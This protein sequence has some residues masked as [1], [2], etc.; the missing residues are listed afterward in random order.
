MMRKF[1]LFLL[2]IGLSMCQLSAN[3][4]TR[5]KIDAERQVF[6]TR[7]ASEGTKMVRVVACGSTAEKAIEQ[8][9]CDA[10]AAISFTGAKGEGEMDA[11]PPVLKDGREQYTKHKK[12]F[13]KFFNKGTYLNY[14]SRVNSTYPAGKDNIKTSKGR[15]VQ[16]YLIVDWATLAKY[17]KDAGFQTTISGLTDF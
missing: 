11:I 12:E 17:F 7:S 14:V 4:K 15:K 9:M 10:V 6:A 13:N 5:F 1:L 16:V 2:T 8:A 3:G